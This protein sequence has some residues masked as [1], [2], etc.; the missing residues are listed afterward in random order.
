MNLTNGEAPIRN[1]HEYTCNSAGYQNE[2]IFALIHRRTKP[3]VL[4]ST[5]GPAATQ[6]KLIS[7]QPL[8]T[9][10][11]VVRNTTLLVLV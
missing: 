3:I 4:T 8:A 2:L 5:R 10:D 1:A 6:A 9:Y 11:V 7:T